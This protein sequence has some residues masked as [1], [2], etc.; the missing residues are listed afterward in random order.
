MPFRPRVARGRA[1]HGLRANRRRRWPHRRAR[2]RRPC[3]PAAVDSSPARPAFPCG[4]HPGAAARHSVVLAIGNEAR[5]LPLRASAVQGDVHVI[6][7]WDYVRWPSRSGS[8]RR[9][10]RLR[11]DHG[12]LAVMT[13]AAVGHRGRIAV[14]SRHGLTPL[15]HA[16][17]GHQHLD[18]AALQALSTRARMRAVRRHARD[19]QAAG[20]PWQWTFD[21]LRH[22]TQALWLHAG[23]EER[24]R[25]LRLPRA[26][27]HP[28]P[29]H[30][31]RV[32]D[33]LVRLRAAGQLQVHAGVQSLTPAAQGRRCSCGS[34]RAVGGGRDRGARGGQRHGI[35]MTRAQQPAAAAGAG[36]ARRA[37]RATGPWARHRRRRHAACA[38]RSRAARCWRGALSISELWES[39]ASRT[40]RPGRG[41]SSHPYGPSPEPRPL[42]QAEKTP[43]SF[44][45]LWCVTARSADVRR[46]SA[47]ARRRQRRPGSRLAKASMKRSWSRF[48][49]CT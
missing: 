19:N 10:R 36:R 38:R 29:P 9:R 30:R 42:P 27:G 48:T 20:L 22:H 37:S 4:W 32:A 16:E 2:R 3:R 18:V 40:S 47:T 25:F 5:G 49:L 46:R 45:P 11:P 17:P 23:A 28:S 14:L 44:Q 31:A 8:G 26:H 13:I 41:P 39:I 34:A 12:R 15:A 21:A 33:T 1:A 35:E 7:A 43:E 6:E 24:A